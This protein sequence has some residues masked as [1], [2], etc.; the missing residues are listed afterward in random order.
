[1]NGCYSLITAA[2][3]ARNLDPKERAQLETL[4]CKLAAKTC[5]AVRA[6]E[7]PVAD[8]VALC[9]TAEGGDHCSGNVHVVCDDNTFAPVAAVD[10]GATGQICG[11]DSGFQSGCGIAPCV[12]G[13]TASTCTG[14]TLTQCQGTGVTQKIDCKTANQIILVKPSGKRTLGSTACGLNE[15]GDPDCIGNGAACTG[16]ASRCDGNV[17]ESCVG[18]KLSRRDCTTVL[19]AG[20]GCV[21]IADAP[22]PHR[23]SARLRPDQPD[24]PRGRQRVMQRGD[25]R[26]SASAR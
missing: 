24:V 10:C 2:P 25:R 4:V 22:G 20:Q 12:Q 18:G 17:L 16:I 19:P 1:M 6:C 7:K 23:G 11:G 21:T 3:F 13:E 15:G 14:D 5:T 26:Q 8:Y 9:Q